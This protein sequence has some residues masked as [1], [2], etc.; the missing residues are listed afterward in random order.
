MPVLRGAWPVLPGDRHARRFETHAAVRYRAGRIC[1]RAQCH[2]S[3]RRYRSGREYR[4]VTRALGSRR[5]AAARAHHDPRPQRRQADRLP[6]SSGNV[7]FSRGE[8]AEWRRPADGGCPE[9]RGADVVRCQGGVDAR[10]AILARRHVPCQRRNPARH[11]L[12]TR[13][14]RSGSARRRRRRMGAGR[15]A[16]RRALARHSCERQGPCGADGLF[17]CRRRQCADACASELSGRAASRGDGRAAPVRAERGRDRAD[18]R[19]PASPLD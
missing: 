3:C 7:S 13:L 9:R 6:R 18:G 2:T 17:A 8:I 15:N 14:S 12:R 1:L 16:D 5:C 19:R 10:T 4:A 11:R